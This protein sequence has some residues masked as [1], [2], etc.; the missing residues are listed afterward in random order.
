MKSIIPFVFL[1]LLSCNSKKETMLMPGAYNMLSSST[2]DGKKDTTYTTLKEFKIYTQDYMMYVNISPRD[3]V[4]RFGI[5][6]YSADSGKVIEDIIYGATD[7]TS[8]SNPASFMLLIEKTDKGYKQ[9]IP[10]L[11][12]RGI[13]YRLT[14]DYET[15][16]T[17][18][19]T[20]LDGAWKQTKAYRIKGKDTVMQKVIQF[21]TFFAGHFMFGH[22]YVDSNNRQHT[23]IG[24]GT[25]EFN[26]KDKLKEHV[27]TTTYYQIRGKDIDIDVEMMGQDAYK[28]TITN[29]DGTK[30]VEEYQL[31]KK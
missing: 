5:G 2:F 24:Y 18:A 26:G 31:L 6:T 29:A 27:E 14:E 12:S 8:S 11:V 25:F 9:V 30:D 22:T 15:V 20:P 13:K 4:S 19:K 7:S 3:S 23:G 17:T 28:Q 1:A 21:K 16:S 10:E